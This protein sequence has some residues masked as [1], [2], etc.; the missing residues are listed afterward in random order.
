MNKGT[1]D[2][3]GRSCSHSGKLLADIEVP[4]VISLG[5][6]VGQ[7][8]RADPKDSRAN[9][10]AP[11]RS[12]AKLLPV[13]KLAT[14]NYVIYRGQCPVGMIQVTMQHPME[15]Y[16]FGLLEWISLVKASDHILLHHSATNK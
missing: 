10:R 8:R 14:S 12:I 16:N 3:G 5:I 7:M 11:G 13:I 15:L 4:E 6:G 1:G 9:F 2:S